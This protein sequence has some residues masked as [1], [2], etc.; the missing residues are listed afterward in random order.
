VDGH[1]E[2]AEITVSILGISPQAPLN[3]YQII[4]TDQPT[5]GPNGGLFL[6][7]GLCDL[8]LLPVCRLSAG[9]P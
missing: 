5:P 8:P 6:P 3:R 1:I 9:R 7:L 2:G 4:T